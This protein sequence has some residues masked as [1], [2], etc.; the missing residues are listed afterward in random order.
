[1]RIVASRNRIDRRGKVVNNGALQ[2]LRLETF[3]S[4][5]AGGGPVIPKGATHA[6]V[7]AGAGK[8]GFNFLRH[9]ARQRRSSST[10]GTAAAAPLVQL[11]STVLYQDST[12]CSPDPA[13]IAVA[14]DLLILYGAS[15]KLGKLSVNFGAARQSG[16]AR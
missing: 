3:A 5:A 14:G 15:G 7:L 6:I 11:S 16:E 9:F 13:A 2:V 1:M 12:P 4:P 10:C 8:Q